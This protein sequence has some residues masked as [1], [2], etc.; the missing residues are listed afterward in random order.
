MIM[1]IFLPARGLGLYCLLLITTLIPGRGKAQA[2]NFDDFFHIRAITFSSPD[3]NNMIYDQLHDVNEMVY[4]LD[5]VLPFT[6]NEFYGAYP[7][8]HVSDTMSF[9]PG[10]HDQIIPSGFDDKA[11]E[12]KGSFTLN[13]KTGYWYAYYKKSIVD[14][15]TAIVILPGSGYHESFQVANE[16]PI[17]YH[18]YGCIIKNKCLDYGDV[19]ITVKINEDFRSI[20]KDTSDNHYNKLDYDV[21]GPYSDYMG[22]NW[23]ANLYIELLG[24]LKYLQTKYKRVLLLGL[25]NGGFPALVCG[26]E[27]NI[28]GINCASGLSTSSYT[29]FPVPNNEN[30]YF[31]NLFSYYSLEHLSDMIHHTGTTILF[32]Y[33]SADCCTNAFEHTTHS[34]QDT[35]NNPVPACNTEF[36]YNFSGHTFPCVALNDYFTKTIQSPKVKI[37]LAP[38]A[39]AY[40][41]LTASLQLDG[42]APYSMD[43]YK[44]GSFDRHFTSYANMLNITLYDAGEY[45]IANLTDANNYPLCQSNSFTYTKP[46]TSRGFTSLISQDSYLIAQQCPYRYY[47]YKDDICIDSTRENTITPRGSGDYY[48]AITDSAGCL[49]KSNTVTQHYPFGINLYPNP[50]NDYVNILIDESFTGSW[51]YVVY[52]EQ[53]QR[54]TSGWSAMPHKLVS[55]RKLARGIYNFRIEYKDQNGKNQRKT[56]SVIKQ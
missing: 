10:L 34:L 50:V 43:L 44:N 30:P 45:Y 52:N 51:S 37:T 25:S 53:G 1:K 35:L 6:T 22:K 16:N 14:T 26:L 5:S 24:Q 29:G 48:V 7:G 40:D 23:A 8:I 21:L 19:Y 55:T 2:F 38:A 39:C 47:W 36:F 42:T 18:N 15:T 49:F 20:W 11:S 17:D 33:G 3:S 46:A 9:L 32:S 28:D 31:G 27:A 12:V 4:Q 56:I 54:I 13:D 41:S